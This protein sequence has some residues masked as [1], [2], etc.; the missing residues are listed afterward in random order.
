M[1]P[2]EED[3][4]NYA[5]FS[6]TGRGPVRTL[7]I[8][9]Q[10]CSASLVWVQN[11]RGL[12]SASHLADSFPSIWKSAQQELG[13]TDEMANLDAELDELLGGDDSDE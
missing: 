4:H 10:G 5:Q 2:P 8:K 9:Y 13:I 12:A 1:E 7:H 6:I 3:A 11:A